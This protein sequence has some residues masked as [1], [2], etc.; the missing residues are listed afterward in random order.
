LP[1]GFNP[2]IPFSIFRL[3]I[4]SGNF[5]AFSQIWRKQ[6]RGAGNGFRLIIM[7]SN[8]FMLAMSGRRASWQALCTLFHIKAAATK[9]L[10][11]TEEKG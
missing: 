11:T 2:G 4:K 8:F 5:Q 1:G 3:T 7:A 10:T 6:D 9:R